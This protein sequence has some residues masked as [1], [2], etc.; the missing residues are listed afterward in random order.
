MAVVSEPP[1]A[2]PDQTFF[3]LSAVESPPTAAPLQLFGSALSS[4]AVLAPAPPAP[5]A[6]PDEDPVPV[7]EQTPTSAPDIPALIQ[8]P[9]AAAALAADVA[10]PAAPS[11]TTGE[12]SGGQVTIEDLGP[13]EEEDLSL[14]QTKIADEGNRGNA[15]LQEND[16]SR[17]V[18]LCEDRPP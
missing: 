15:D 1:Q 2:N 11:E 17:N 12:D 9:E 13:D 10:P 5:A 6:A 8:A 18:E 7:Q 16:R 3:T 4:V 14:S